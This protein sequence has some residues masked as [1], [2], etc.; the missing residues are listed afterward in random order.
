MICT[1]QRAKEDFI[2]INSATS[3]ILSWQDAWLICF[4]LNFHPYYVV[5]YFFCT[6]KFIICTARGTSGRKRQMAKLLYYCSEGPRSTAQFGLLT[7]CQQETR[8]F[9]LLSRIASFPRK[10]GHTSKDRVAPYFRNPPIQ[11]ITERLK[12]FFTNHIWLQHK[13]SFTS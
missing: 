8:K 10:N 7:T 13:H 6:S 4:D 11:M 3:I 2:L 9:I 12:E 5:Y 1:A